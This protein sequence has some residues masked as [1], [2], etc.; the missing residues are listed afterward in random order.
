MKAMSSDPQQ[1][2]AAV[3]NYSRLH[4]NAIKVS[5][6]STNGTYKKSMKL[7]KRKHRETLHC[8]IESICILITT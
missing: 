2:R 5:F 8:D 7:R 4:K 6:C 3:K 1:G